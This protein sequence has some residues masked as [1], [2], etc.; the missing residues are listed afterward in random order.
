MKLPYT[1]TGKTAVEAGLGAIGNQEFCFGHVKFEVLLD[2]QVE[3][4]MPRGAD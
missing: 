4:T 1:E 2:I 3:S